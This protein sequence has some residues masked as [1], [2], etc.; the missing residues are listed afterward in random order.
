MVSSRGGEKGGGGQWRRSRMSR[1]R[2]AEEEVEVSARG[3]GGGEQQ[4]WRSTRR[5]RATEEKE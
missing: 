5:W 3:K 4:M 1:W 2:A